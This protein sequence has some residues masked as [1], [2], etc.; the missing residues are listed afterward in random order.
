MY[1]FRRRHLWGSNLH[2]GYSFPLR[3]YLE[4]S[5]IWRRCQKIRVRP[6]YKGYMMGGVGFLGGLGSGSSDHKSL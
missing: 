6:H 5:A 2:V 1:C 4:W 3:C